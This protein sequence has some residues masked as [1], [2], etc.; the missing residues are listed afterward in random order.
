[1]SDQ[2]LAVSGG[3]NLYR[4]PLGM[5]ISENT[6]LL[7][8][9]QLKNYPT[10]VVSARE[11]MKAIGQEVSTADVLSLWES[12]DQQMLRDTRGILQPRKIISYI[13]VDA[14]LLWENPDPSMTKDPNE[15]LEPEIKLLHMVEPGGPKQLSEL[16]HVPEQ[17][18][19]TK[20]LIIMGDRDGTENGR[21]CKADLQASAATLFP[22]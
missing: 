1:M 17:E 20:N 8:S 4:G 18:D 6:D 9:D 11:S 2:V 10:K 19:M 7:I 13:Q 12:P 21:V 15:I 22:V 16:L 3:L 5:T 14:L